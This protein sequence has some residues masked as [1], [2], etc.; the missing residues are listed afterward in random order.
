M[1]EDDLEGLMLLTTACSMA[2][3]RRSCARI[4]DEP[5]LAEQW[6]RLT[7]LSQVLEHELQA[8]PPPDFRTRSHGAGAPNAS[9]CPKPYE[10][11]RIEPPD[12]RP[13]AAVVARSPCGRWGYPMRSLRATSRA[14]CGCSRRAAGGA[15]AGETEIE[16]IDNPTDYNVLVLAAPGSQNR[17]I[18]ISQR[19]ISDEG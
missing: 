2:S 1:W 10:S 7:A 8:E 5:E 6:R 13:A 18:W 19:Q 16:S 9:S 4:E 11:P 17:M 15:R 14:C 3:T 12:R